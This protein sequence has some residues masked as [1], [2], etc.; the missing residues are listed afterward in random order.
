MTTVFQCFPVAYAWDKDLA[1]KCV[2][3]NTVSWVNAAVNI[4]QDMLVVLLPI[5]ELQILQLGV[6]KMIG[7]YVM[8]GLGFL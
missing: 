8:F 3:Y 7:L 1:G 2:D 5:P 6:R 4:L